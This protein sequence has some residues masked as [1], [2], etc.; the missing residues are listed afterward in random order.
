MKTMRLSRGSSFHGSSGSPE[1]SMWTPWK[2]NFMSWPRMLRMP[3][4][5][6]MLTPSLARRSVSHAFTRTM[7]SA[8]ACRRPMDVI[9]SSC[10]CSPSVS[11]KSGSM[12]ST[13]LRSKASTPS[14]KSSAKPLARSQRFS[15]AT[16]FS[17][18]SFDSTAASSPSSRR[19]HLFRR[20][21][22]AKATCS[23]ASFSTPS[24]FCSSRC[25]TMCFA[26]TTVTKASSRARSLST[27]STKKVWATGA[28]SAKPV[29]SMMMP[30]NFATFF[31][32]FF[33]VS[34]RSPRTVQQMQPF[35]TSMISS[36]IFSLICGLMIFSS[37]PTS[38]NSFSM[39]ANFMPWSPRSRWLSSVV[40]PLPRK[41][42]S[43]VTCAA[44][45]GGEPARS[46]L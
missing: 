12:S 29:V 14:T 22:S 31:A 25:C 44:R 1:K 4:M 7:S 35:M 15:G 6:K 16:L 34:T 2:T 32:S 24:G 36:S 17:D 13:F 33:S 41:P 40:L 37:M 46:C 3:F 38:P 39:I 19:S 42:V 11:R 20:M 28:G 23:T 30:S 10:T 8:P 5:R 43:T 18:R 26:S 45:G 27:S 9:E 21:R